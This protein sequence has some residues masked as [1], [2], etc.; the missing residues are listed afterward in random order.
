MEKEKINSIIISNDQYYKDLG[1]S[2]EDIKIALLFSID[3]INAL[4]L[5]NMPIRNNKFPEVLRGLANILELM[6]GN[7]DG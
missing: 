1:W 5:L 2:D 6:N 4:H 7:K 3:L